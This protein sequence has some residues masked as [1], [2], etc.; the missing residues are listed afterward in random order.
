[1][2][3]HPYMYCTQICTAQTHPRQLFEVVLHGILW[4]P[5]QLPHLL[6]VP[7]HLCLVALHLLVVQQLACGGVLQ[8]RGKE[9]N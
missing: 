2:Y 6:V 9:M 1:M 5:W 8:D 3:T 4:Y 7:L